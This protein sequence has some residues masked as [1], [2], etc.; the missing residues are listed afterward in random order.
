MPSSPLRSASASASP[1]NRWVSSTLRWLR[2]CRLLPAVVSHPSNK[3]V[4]PQDHP[5]L[6]DLTEFLPGFPQANTDW[7][8]EGVRDGLRNPSRAVLIS[9]ILG[10]DDGPHTN[11][12]QSLPPIL[13]PHVIVPEGGGR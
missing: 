6:V 12:H 9:E 13:P 10:P 1:P 8:E 2:S 11:L 5:D 4:P 7:R 3:V